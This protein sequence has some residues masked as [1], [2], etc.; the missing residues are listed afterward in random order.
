MPFRDFTRAPSQQKGV[1]AFHKEST[2]QRTILGFRWPYDEATVWNHGKNT[3]N[4]ER[5]TYE[6]SHKTVCNRP[7]TD[8]QGHRAKRESK[9]EEKLFS[10]EGRV[11]GEE[12]PFEFNGVNGEAPQS[13]GIEQRKELIANEKNLG[14]LEACGRSRRATMD[15]PTVGGISIA[16]CPKTRVIS[17]AI[18][19]ESN[20]VVIDEGIIL[21]VGSTVL[22][23]QGTN[24]STSFHFGFLILGVC[25]L[26]VCVLFQV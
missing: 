13:L 15:V 20:T 4:D 9:R 1:G 16:I 21:N 10:F 5:E 14:P 17:L 22:Y 25:V 19:I 24:I 3:D 18:I 8:V 26:G 2:R 12:T 23:Q 11:E 6:Q 7:N